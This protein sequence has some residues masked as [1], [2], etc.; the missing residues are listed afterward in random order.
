[1]EQGEKKTKSSVN[2][3][4]KHNIQEELNH[5]NM[6][7]PDEMIE[8]HDRL[9]FER[10]EK[11]DRQMVSGIFRNN[12]TPGG[13]HEFSFRKYAGPIEDYSFKDG[14]QYTV[15]LYIARHLNNDCAYPVYSSTNV[16]TTK[17]NIRNNNLDV[18]EW[19]RRFSF[20]SL[21]FAKR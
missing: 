12:E 20:T 9:E 10:K 13:E 2:R 21:D 7:S 5:V 16:K 11:E 3:N 8:Y 15:P 19:I 17:N 14:E 4:E 1:M 6:M 18:K